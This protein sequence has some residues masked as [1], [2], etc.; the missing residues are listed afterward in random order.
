MPFMGMLTVG[1]IS[2]GGSIV[3]GLL[4]KSASKK[5]ADAQS[6]SAQKALDFQKQVFDTQQ[7][8]MRPY[9]D[10]GVQ[11]IGTIMDAIKAGKFGFG[12]NADFKA[13]T[14]DEARND[15]GYQFIREQGTKAALQG[16]A[17]AGGVGGGTL[18]ALDTF[19]SGLADTTYG[20]VFNRSLQSYGM[21]L[22][23]QG[24]EFGQLFAP[25]QLGENAVA[26]INNTGSVAAAN[27]GSLLTQQGNAQASGIVG[28]ANAIAGGIGGATN[29][30]LQGVTLGN[31]FKGGKA[32]PY[33]PPPGG[34]VP[35]NVAAGQPYVG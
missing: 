8:N 11:S 31:L 3:S 28:G 19:G 24:Q 1:L 34:D 6:Q 26:G 20:N 17:A 33:M 23:K 35:L 18:R 22:Q 10:A 32:P 30:I 16:A 14:I 13:P 2:A 4:G 27:I 21:N 5:A 12:S 25:A 29:S 9:Q 7:Q 15:P